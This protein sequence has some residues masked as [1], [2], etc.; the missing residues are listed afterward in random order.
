MDEKKQTLL[1]L[2][3]LT[4]HLWLCNSKPATKNSILKHQLEH[5]GGDEREGK[6]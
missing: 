3:C 1:V 2:I 5:S 4:E 6:G